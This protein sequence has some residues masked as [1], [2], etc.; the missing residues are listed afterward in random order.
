M[1]TGKIYCITNTANGK[2]YIGQTIVSVESRWREHKNHSNI[3]DYPI[4]RALRK[5]GFDKFSVE[6]IDT[7]KTRESLDEKERMWIKSLCT[8]LPNGYNAI[9]GPPGKSAKFSEETRALL[10]KKLK[11]RWENP[12]YRA[13]MKTSTT[14]IIKGPHSDET[15]KKISDANKGKRLSYERK[16]KIGESSKLLW[17]NKEYAEKALVGIYKSNAKRAKAVINLDTGEIFCSAGEASRKLGV[18][19]Q[20]VT[21]CCQGKR[22]RAGGWLLAYAEGVGE[23]ASKNR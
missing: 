16:R 19:Q 1:S 5:Y 15:K 7:A 13:K 2:K 10:S 6:V 17:G 8:L 18:Y 14:G 23:D 9:D 4:Y 21:K 22:K 12:E 11:K 20:N 3:Y